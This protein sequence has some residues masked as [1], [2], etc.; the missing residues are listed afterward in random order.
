VIIKTLAE[1][2]AL[3]EEYACEHG[4]S[5]YIE[6]ENHKLLFDTGQSDLFIRNAKTMGVDLSQVDT[7]VISHGHY[8]HG[9]GL[10]YFLA[11]N[12]HAAIY[13]NEHAFEPHYGDTQNNIGLQKELLN[14]GKI[15]LTGDHLPIDDELSLFTFN[16]EPRP[17]F[18]SSFGLTVM[19]EKELCPDDFTHEQYLIIRDGDKSV[20]ISGCSH[21]G[22][23]NIMRWTMSYQPYVVVGG[24][25][26]MKLDSD[27][28]NSVVLD[29]MAK[30]LMLYDAKFFTCHCTGQQQYQYLKKSMKG[31][32]NYLS[33][34]QTVTL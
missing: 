28:S 2:T 19:R 22:I 13:I 1:N 8:D 17:F 32:L 15:I 7:V 9:G 5:L 23:L 6:T 16:K 26:L 3:T 31:K 4:L 29:K 27:S 14:N 34:G 10:E 20:L 24:F 30:E 12:D 33:A 18:M 25:H 21:K 11:I